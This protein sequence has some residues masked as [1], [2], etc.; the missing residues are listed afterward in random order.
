MRLHYV[1]GGTGDPVLL[2]HGWLQTSYAWRE[3][4]PALAQH[5]TVIAPD[6]RGYGDSDKPAT[7]YDSLTLVEDFYQLVHSL[8]FQRLFIVAHDMGALP[9]YVYAA[10]HAAE[11]RGLVWLDEPFP[12][13]G[14]QQALQFTAET[15]QA[16]GLWQFFF[17]LVP[18]LP[19]LLIAGKERAFLS[20]FYRKYCYNPQAISEAAIDEYT[21]T[22]SAPGGI[23]GSLGVYRAIFETTQQIQQYAST[24]LA[25]PVLAL[26]G[27]GSL[28][29]HVVGMLQQVAETVR[30]GAVE[31]C[32]HFIAEERPDYLIDQLLIFFRE[33]A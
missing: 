18:D 33:T 3:V 27:E 1:Q 9:A 13:S 29:G 22:F 4:M 21:R 32:G 26:G 12:G 25:M 19:E 28:G 20:Y 2:W 10:E 6:M 31:R 5:Y 24:K 30:G 23:R 7:G 11:V 8:G 16:G 17:N 15:A 14:L